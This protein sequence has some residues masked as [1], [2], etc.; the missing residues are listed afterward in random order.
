MGGLKARIKT[1]FE[2]DQIPLDSW[3]SYAGQLE[4]SALARF[5][6]RRRVWALLQL[7]RGLARLPLTA[8]RV[9]YHLV[10]LGLEIE[11]LHFGPM[12]RVRQGPGCVVDRQTWLITGESIEL[13]AFVKISAF[14]TVMAGRHA[15]VRIGDN[16]II[17]PGVLI[18]AFN[19]GIAERDVPIRYQPWDDQS[20]HSITIGCDVWI[21]AN[22]IILP[23]TTI[24]DGAVIAAG[25][26]ARGVI[27]PNSVIRNR[28]ETASR[29]RNHG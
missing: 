15:K 1:Y 12:R 22:A 11:T 24:G 28:V 14:S 19:H 5:E 7:V 29:G 3:R 25:A 20:E 16:T 9:P 26:L 6:F 23:G 10:L 21:G 8:V 17:G 18:A 27:A 2:M 13:G 4:E